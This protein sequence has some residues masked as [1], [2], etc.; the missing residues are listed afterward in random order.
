MDSQTD[1]TASGMLIEGVRQKFCGK[2]GVSPMVS[3]VSFWQEPRVVKNFCFKIC[4][5]GWNVVRQKDATARQQ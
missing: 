2:D 3:T 1:Y 5:M 4:Q